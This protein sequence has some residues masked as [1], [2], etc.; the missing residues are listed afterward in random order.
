M[1]E[2]LTAAEGTYQETR[3]NLAEGIVVAPELLPEEDPQSARRADYP[4]QLTEGCR[5]CDYGSLC[6]RT[7]EAR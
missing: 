5:F 6:G 7:E 1:H 4:L 2:T 3:N